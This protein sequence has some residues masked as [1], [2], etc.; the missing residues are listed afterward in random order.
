M[1]AHTW[2]C[3]CDRMNSRSPLRSTAFGV[4]I[5]FA[6]VLFTL[7]QSSKQDC[8]W[9]GVCN[10]NIFSHSQNCPY[11]GTAKEMPEDGLEL[12]KRRC[13]FLLENS[14]NKFC[15]DKK[16]VELLNKNVKLAGN[17]L[18]RCPSCMENLVRHICQFTCSPKQTEFMHVVATEKNK[19]D[20][21]Y[22][23]SV[24]LHISTEYINKTYKSCSQH[25]PKDNSDT[26]TPLNVTTIPCNQ[27]VNSKLPAC[28]CSDCDLSCPQGPPEPAPPEPF[29]IGGLDAYF[30]IMAAVFV[31]GVIVF[32]MG[33][34]LFTQ[35]S[36]MDDG[37]EIDVSKCVVQSIWGYFS[38]DPTRLDD[39]DEDNGFNVTYLDGLYDCISNPYLCLAPYGG[40]VD[41]A[42]AFGGF[43]PSGAQLTGNTEYELA[44]ALILTFL[45]KNHHNRTDLQ[46]A[47]MWEKKIIRT[48][49]AQRPA[50]P[51]M[52][53]VF[54]TPTAMK[55]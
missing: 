29:K 48:T 18:D 14:E 49:S 4:H 25:E 22:I 38:D 54:G 6:A 15:C 5:L 50:M 45:V 17:I 23:T 52:V 40:P 1:H 31:V 37:S 43:L 44:N 53:E 16:Q 21:E 41:P 20:V 30:V 28:S 33:S 19:E 47:L 26:F 12:L 13:G 39:H 32:L 27:A 2:I 55:D 35:G 11:N 42:I 10:T 34:F 36:S 3:D 24:D 8:V 7:I 51:L 9:Y 46:P